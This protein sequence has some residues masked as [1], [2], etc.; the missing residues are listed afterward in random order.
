MSY[1]DEN[2]DIYINIYGGMLND[3]DRQLNTSSYDSINSFFHSSTK[4]HHTID[5]KPAEK[6]VEICVL[7]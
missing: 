6:A 1:A 3:D 4:Y 2:K 7:V 5:Q